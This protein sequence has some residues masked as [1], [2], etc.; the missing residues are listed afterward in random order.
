MLGGFSLHMHEREIGGKTEITK[1][2]TVSENRPTR[3]DDDS[4]IDDDVCRW[5][6]CVAG[7]E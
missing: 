1:K 4:S 3:D 5:N 2:K 6:I 7:V